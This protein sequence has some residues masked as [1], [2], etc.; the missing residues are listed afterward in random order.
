MSLSEPVQDVQ[1]DILGIYWGY[2]GVQ[3]VFSDIKAL[4]Y[5][6]PQDLSAGTNPNL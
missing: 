1:G 4:K 5:Q 3:R 2:T 6:I